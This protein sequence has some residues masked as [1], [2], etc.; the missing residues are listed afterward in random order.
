MHEVS[1]C[2]SIVK[3]IERRAAQEG[4][5]HVV[6]IELAVGK[7]SGASTEALDF[8]FPFVAKGTV[9]E[10]ARLTFVATEGRDLRV[11]AMEVKT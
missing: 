4:F 1:L 8:S 5:T 2:E 3:I 9:A 6:G 10:G 7:L 11:K